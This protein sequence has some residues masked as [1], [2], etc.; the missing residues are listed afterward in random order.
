MED[1]QEAIVCFANQVRDLF[2]KP[3]VTKKCMYEY[4]VKNVDAEKTLDKIVSFL[5]FCNPFR[6]KN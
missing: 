1:K 2:G 5:R 4:F 3:T 6:K